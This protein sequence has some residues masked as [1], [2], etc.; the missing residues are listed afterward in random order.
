MTE[1][2]QKKGKEEKKKNK[3]KSK[4]EDIDEPPVA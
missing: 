2:M 1:A 3:H 4:H